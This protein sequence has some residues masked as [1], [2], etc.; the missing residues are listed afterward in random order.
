MP[1]RSLILFFLLSCSTKETPMKD[2]S[3]EYSKGEI[4]LASKLLDK[5]F[6]KQMAPIECIKDTDEAELLIRTL[7]PRLEVV[8]DDIEAQLDEPNEI[9]KL[10]KRCQD[11]C[12]CGHLDEIFKEH[13][14][15]LSKAQKKAMKEK[16]SEKEMSRCLNFAQTTFCQ[17]ELYKSLNEEKKDFSFEESP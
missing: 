17:S 15:E 10:I 3:K 16:A 4:I 14:V 6:D 9:E 2:R 8:Q 11:D 12:T 7:T 13:Q 5:I 1:V